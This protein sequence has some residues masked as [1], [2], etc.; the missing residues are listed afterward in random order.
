[1]S[2]AIDFF[3]DGW[4]K[5]QLKAPPSLQRTVIPRLHAAKEFARLLAKPYLP[6]YQLQGQGQG[7]SLS[8]TFI[9]WEYAKP[10][11]QDLLFVEKP[12][13]HKIGRIPF[14]RCGEWTELFS[15]DLV[16]VGA[17][18]R[19][20]RSLPRQQAIVLP[21]FIHH[22]VDVRGN[23]QDVCKRFHKTIRKNEL[24]WIRKYHYEYELSHLHQDF[25]EFHEQMYLP[26]MSAR[27]GQLA[28]PMSI[29]E[30]YQY[31]LHG[32]LFKINRAGSWVSGVICEPQ[33][34]TL[35]ARIL[36]VRNADPELIRQ[37]AISATYYA[38]I[39]WAN[40][41]R[42]E[43]VN[44][45]GT[46]PYLRLGLFQQKRKWGATLSLPATL[47]RQIWIGVRRLTPGVSR[48]LKENPM[49]IEHNGTLQGL[50]IVDDP[51]QVPAE[52]RQEWEDLYVTPGLS[53]LVIRSVHDLV[54]PTS[55]LGS[56]VIIPMPCDVNRENH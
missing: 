12:L 20:V 56:D 10:A 33:Q 14:W 19:L 6:V 23:W 16:I 7:G 26:S 47:H 18:K 51:H 37:G 55:V 38:A 11:L 9:G 41:Q 22:I 21:E 50:I 44:F 48:F 31:F 45:L 36:G 13:E 43:A 27:H 2:P 5:A 52:S 34:H 3:R 17:A 25:Q 49:V 42:Y 30:A 39:H 29:G 54:E 32:G 46:E 35:N 15:T 28:Q 1:M 4:I 24:R 8:V 40:Q 53:Q